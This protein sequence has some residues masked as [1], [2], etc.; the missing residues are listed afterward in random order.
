MNDRQEIRPDRDPNRNRNNF[1]VDAKSNSIV[2]VVEAD[3]L[4]QLKELMR[5]LD[6]PKKMVQIEV[7]LFEKKLKRQ[8]DFGLNLL[9]IGSKASDTHT[10]SA[11]WND[12]KADRGIFQYLLSREKGNG[13]LPAFDLIYKFL[14]TQDDITINATPSVVAMNQTP[15]KI[16]VDEEISVN[17]GIF[18]I[19]T[20][21]A[22]ALKDSF[23]RARYGIKI[24]I[25]PTIH[26]PDENACG[27]DNVAYVTMD[28][29]VVFETFDRKGHNPKQPDVTRRYIRN[30]VRVADGET[31]I[32]GGLRRKI[33]E[34]KKEMIPFIG[35]L[36]G[37]G[38]LFSMTEMEDA[39]TEMYIFITPRII[40]SPQEDARRI[41]T[42]E[43]CRRPGDIPSFLGH[44][45]KAREREQSR[46]MTGAMDMLFGRERERIEIP[47][48]EYDGRC[49]RK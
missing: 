42:Q 19:P 36:P 45:V 25:I 24:E 46:M 37:F 11:L 29:D 31:V 43:L 21:G 32:L 17:T 23:A 49:H 18:E 38:K 30:E 5:K 8:N 16:H 34:D 15:A 14:M 28:T 2:M 10:S 9:K 1:I 35:E 27:P 22:V 47:C 40:Y 4:S 48:G 26:L 13:G 44:L 7:L 39:S 41:R 3:Y 6:V 12:S 20:E 33:T